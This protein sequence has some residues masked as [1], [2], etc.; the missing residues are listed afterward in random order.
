MFVSDCISVN[1][2]GHLTVGGCDTVEISKEF[3]TPAYVY[4][5]NE[6]RKNIREF[7]KL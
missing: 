6:I 5:E 1:E 3:G 2:K 7:R 4:D